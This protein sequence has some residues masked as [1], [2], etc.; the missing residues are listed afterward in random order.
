M[1]SAALPTPEYHGIDMKPSRLVMV[2]LGGQR[3]AAWLDAV[4]QVGQPWRDEIIE[5]LSEIPALLEAEHHVLICYAAPAHRLALAIESG[6]VPSQALADWQHEAESLLALYRRHHRHVTLATREALYRHP[7]RLC[8]YIAGRSGISL[9]GVVLNESSPGVDAESAVPHSRMSHRL[10]ALHALTHPPAKR[11][12]Q[13]LEESSMPLDSSPG[14]LAV[15]DDL[16]ETQRKLPAGSLGEVGEDVDD[17]RRETDML[18]EHLHATQEEL[19]K[20]L[21]VQRKSEKKI[22]ALEQDI[23]NKKKKIRRSALELQAV[24]ENS[25]QELKLKN[26]SL[27]TLLRSKKRV[28][29]QLDEAHR[30]LGVV[31]ASRSWRVTA[32]LRLGMKMFARKPGN[33]P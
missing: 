26:D 7:Q 28:M 9:G 1:S 11:L 4:R 3:P 5:S 20:Y 8:E 21:L 31:Y 29:T 19:E 10:L 13:E 17:L 16:Y 12:V 32:P 30:Q 2:N 22:A 23:K 15:L 18:I 27:R 14:V 25:S 33:S 6:Q 24:K